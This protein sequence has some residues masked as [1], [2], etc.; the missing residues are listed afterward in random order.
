MEADNYNICKNCFLTASIAYKFYL[1]T[2]RSEEILNYYVDELSRNVLSIEI[3]VEVSND[4]IC[5]TLPEI[6]P[7]T[8]NFD[9]SLEGCVQEHF[10]KKEAHNK[11][12][13]PRKSNFHNSKLITEEKEDSD[14][15]NLVVIVSENKNGKCFLQKHITASRKFESNSI[16]K[17]HIK[18]ERKKRIPMAY[19]KCSKCPVRYRFTAKLKEHMKQEHNIDLF[20]CKVNKNILPS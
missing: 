4:S 15:E 10:V 19:R 18:K 13:N 9:Y 7:E 5:I 16:Q 8:K 11:V 1:L 14:D 3:P 20:I 12:D 2:K 6:I 17:E